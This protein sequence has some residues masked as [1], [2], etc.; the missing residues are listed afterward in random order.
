MIVIYNVTQYYISPLNKVVRVLKEI[1]T[2][3][4]YVN[5][6]I[7]N[8]YWNEI[9]LELNKLIDK[10]KNDITRIESLGKTRTQFL[11][12][13]SHELKTPIFTLKGYVEIL[14]DGAIDDK[15]VN[16]EFLHKIK[17]QAYRLE[18]IFTDLIDITRIE[19]GELH[20]KFDWLNFNEFLF[21]VK[22]NFEHLANDR[23]LKLSIPQKINFEVFADKNRLQTVFSNLITN[24]INYSDQG[25]I[26]LSVKTETDKLMIKVLD[27]GI[28]IL[29]ENQK[30]IFERFYREDPNRSRKTG[31]SGLGLAIV[32][33]I[34]DAHQ[35][36]ILIESQKHIGTTIGF[37]LPF[38]NPIK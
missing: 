33:H 7:I 25:I 27:N 17:S 26:R 11:A 12:N 13:V 36:D 15:N 32:K 31:G 4:R 19:S 35:T 2:S 8:P 21:W 3:S 23:G 29:P 16:K 22:E 14:L 34:L 5:T 6:E 9:E 10:I 18:A 28:G 38:R 1:R 30:R 20:M 24:A 37:L